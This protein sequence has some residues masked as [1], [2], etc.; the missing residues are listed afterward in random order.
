M[1]NPA[2][3]AVDARRRE[4]WRTCGTGVSGAHCGR[5]EKTRG[6]IGMPS[7]G[8][9]HRESRGRRT[10]GWRLS[11]SRTDVRKNPQHL[12][13]LQFGVGSRLRRLDTRPVCEGWETLRNPWEKRAT[14]LPSYLGN[15]LST[16][17]MVA[18]QVGRE[19]SS[20]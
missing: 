6:G 13:V 10:G 4:S 8:S 16:F 11:L 3:I 12:W 14:C 9:N 5:D 20:R 1:H 19:A 2:K 17:K 18:A 7:R 15:S